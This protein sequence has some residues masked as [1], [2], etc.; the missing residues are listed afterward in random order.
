MKKANIGKIIVNIIIICAYSY[1]LF[2]IIPGFFDE[3]KKVEFYKLVTT[4]L[5]TTSGFVI[6]MYNNFKFVFLMWNKLKIRFSNKTVRWEM[7]YRTPQVTFDD[8]KKVN[9]ELIK[10]IKEK[11]TIITKEINRDESKIITIS[12]SRNIESVFDVRWNKKDNT[13]YSFTIIFK[14]QTSHIEVRKQWDFY[15]SVI[16]ETLQVIPR[17]SNHEK[18]PSEHKSYYT[19]SLN[20]E[21]NPFYLL[22]I[23]T[24]DKPS[25]IK[26]DLSFKADGVT[27]KT[28]NGKIV[29]TTEDPIK[30]NTVLKNYVLL[31]KVS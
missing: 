13:N 1:S 19:V 30:V 14:S 27:F 22:T 15:K 10:V 2:V 21:K 25:N 28:S 26:F 12:N 24:Y 11:K 6:Y 17:E 29:I 7:T 9:A 5:S 16:D 18:K 23:K 4:L 31:G 20:M 8:I 3:E